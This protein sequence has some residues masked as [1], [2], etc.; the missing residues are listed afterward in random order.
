METTAI[1]GESALELR[2]I[3]KRF[4][5]VRALDDVSVAIRPGE[6]HAIIGQNGA[7]KSTMINVVSGMIRADSGS[8]LLTGR[9][10][11]IDSTR[12][13]LELG[14]AT[15]YQELSLLP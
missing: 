11:T 13:A 5:G 10:V 7:G 15:V 6:V 3:S 4:P 1:F 12:T 9:P 2:D 8:I 14:I